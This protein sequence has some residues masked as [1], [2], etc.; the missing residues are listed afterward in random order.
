MS[1]QFGHSFCSTSG[2][3]G[4]Q[5]SQ[6]HLLIHRDQ[7][8]DRGRL[9][10]AGAACNCHNAVRGGNLKRFP[11]HRRIANPLFPLNGEDDRVD[12]H[13]GFYIGRRH[14]QQ[15]LR[16]IA[17][18]FIQ[19][20]EI[21]GAASG[22][23]GFRNVAAVDQH[24]KS[25]ADRLLVDADQLRGRRNQFFTRNEHM[26]VSGIVLQF[27]HNGGRDAL[28]AVGIHSEVQRKLVGV[29]EFASDIRRG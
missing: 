5:H 27:K 23:C 3:R 10:G 9:S 16:R 4:E 29:G 7:R 28:R 6:S 22:N 1:G 25:V 8:A 26:S 13:G 2:R 20:V 14:P 17:F 18:R 19:R 12:I 24:V 21:A 15:T 11:L